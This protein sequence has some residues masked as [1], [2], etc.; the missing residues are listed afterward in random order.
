LEEIDLDNNSVD[1][2]ALLYLQDCPYMIRADQGVLGLNKK[3]VSGNLK[4]YPEI[5]DL[6]NTNQLKTVRSVC[7]YFNEKVSVKKVPLSGSDK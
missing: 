6:I 5:V 1:E 4:D 2:I 3:A 7:T